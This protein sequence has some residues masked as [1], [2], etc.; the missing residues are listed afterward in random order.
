MSAEEQDI[1]LLHQIKQ[2]EENLVKEKNVEF[3]EI[4]P[5]KVEKLEVE[6][7]APGPAVAEIYGAITER[8]KIMIPEFA[9]SYFDEIDKKV[10]EF[11]IIYQFIEGGILVKETD[12]LL[13]R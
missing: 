9:W 2:E 5:E 10:N 11:N 6:V 8:R 7:I 13:N 12:D 4:V 1:N 3:E